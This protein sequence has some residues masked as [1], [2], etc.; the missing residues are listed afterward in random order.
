MHCLTMVLP[1]ARPGERWRRLFVGEPEGHR[2]LRPGPPT[3]TVQEEHVGGFK[4]ANHHRVA[5]R[6]DSASE[7]YEVTVEVRISEPAKRRPNPNPNPSPHP[8]PHP[9]PN[10]NPNPNPNPNPD[11]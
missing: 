11:D 6:K 9:H 10:L 4:P 5:A 8:H 3:H 7:Q 1:K 2:E